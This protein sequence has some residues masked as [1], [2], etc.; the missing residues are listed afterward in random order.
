MA[1]AEGCGKRPPDTEAGA[2]DGKNG[3][4]QYRHG[5]VIAD[6]FMGSGS[7]GVA[8]VKMGRSFVGVEI[9]PKYFDMACSRIEQAQ[10]Q[11]QMFDYAP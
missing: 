4:G 10:R 7:T 1:S 3:S 9:E 11:A 6:P 5:G 2:V 8:A